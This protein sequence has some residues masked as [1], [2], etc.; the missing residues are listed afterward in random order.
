VKERRPMWA[1]FCI[2]ATV[3]AQSLLKPDVAVEKL[4]RAT[5]A[6]TELR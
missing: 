2:S 4:F 3:A 5:L 6:K 1:A